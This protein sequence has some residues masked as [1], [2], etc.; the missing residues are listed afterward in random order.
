MGRSRTDPSRIASRVGGDRHGRAPLIVPDPVMKRPRFNPLRR[1]AAPRTRSATRGHDRIHRGDV[2]RTRGVGS[3][4]CERGSRCRRGPSM[5]KMLSTRPE[6]VDAGD[7]SSVIVPSISDRLHEAHVFGH[8]RDHP[9]PNIHARRLLPRNPKC[10][11]SKS[12][13]PVLWNRLR[14]GRESRGKEPWQ[15]A[16]RPPPG[17]KLRQRCAGGIGIAG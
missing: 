1:P 8:D 11:R 12:L 14:E 5:A 13:S 16:Q 9:V 15:T 7:L 4:A 3:L 10:G 2:E 6:T 17:G